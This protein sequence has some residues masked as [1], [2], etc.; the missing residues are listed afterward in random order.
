MADEI[1]EEWRKEFEHTGEELVRSYYFGKYYRSNAE[2]EDAALCW[3][4]EKRN[5]RDR[6]GKIM[7]W[8][9]VV[10]AVAGLAGL[11]VPFI[12]G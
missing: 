3:L 2:K 10:S 4:N 11:V 6:R 5:E 1:R 8:L 9:V 7:F 12:V